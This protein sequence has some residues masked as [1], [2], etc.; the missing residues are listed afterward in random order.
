M[1]LRIS[2]LTDLRHHEALP[3]LEVT[4]MPF[5]A[6][7]ESALAPGFMV[8]HGN[9]LEDLRGVAVEWMK[10]H[11]LGPL[12]N[13][14]ILVQSNGISQWLKLALAADERDDGTGGSGIAAAL[15]ITLPARFLWQAYRAVLNH[16]EHDPQA[17]PAT[18]PFDKSHLLWRLLR[19]LPELMERDE[20]APLRQF[21]A[22][23]DDLRKHYQLAE[24]LADLFDQY[25]VYR[26]DWLDAWG[27]GEDVLISARGE[28]HPLEDAQRWQP[29]LWRA[30]RHDVA[31]QGRAVGES[32]AA[33]VGDQGIASSRAMVHR[34]FM[35]AAGQ[36]DANHRPPGLPRR[37]SARARSRVEFIVVDSD[38][39]DVML[40]WDQTG[41][42]EVSELRG[43]NLPESDDWMTTLLQTKAFHRIPAANIQAIFMRMQQVNYK[44]GDVVIKQGDDGDYFYVITEG[45]CSVTRETP[46]NKDGIKL[47]D[48]GPGDTFG[49]EAL[50]SQ[51]KRNATVTMTSN[52]S[53][54]RLGQA[55]FNTLMNEPM[56]QWVG[57]EEAR[58]I[59]LQGGKW[60]D[61]RLPSE[62]E[63]FHQEG[64][65]NIPLYFIRLKLKTLDQHT[66]YVVCCDTGR[67]SSAAAY[68]LS[69]RGFDAYVLRGGLTMAEAE[70][71][72]RGQ[73]AS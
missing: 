18:S 73:D 40:T 59:I 6:P 43:E 15:D 37:V 22:H 72:R 17:V 31:R 13:E 54:M 50:I 30:I 42:Y 27:R 16:V 10:R 61:V 28:A 44:A 71:V 9:R 57:L 26:A 68:I 49:E 11:P 8:I 19:L 65:I 24:R 35:D 32:V 39:L 69:E 46:L 58:K 63:S 1:H 41:T 47:A 70:D 21:L 66:R 45:R 2:P 25:Q 14:T 64:A 29:A 52:G 34:R 60:L 5:A 23:D 7:Q 3:P 51:A 20:F 38:L 56:L 33:D 4:A 48:L 55:D 36:L 53:L 12:E 67:R 62:F